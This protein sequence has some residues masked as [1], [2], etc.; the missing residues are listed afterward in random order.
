MEKPHTW[1]E[2]LALII[3]DTQQRQQIA[4]RLKINP[5]TLTRWAAGTS[6][7]RPENL[8]SLLNILPMREREQTRNAPVLNHAPHTIMNEIHPEFYRRVLS[9]YT[10]LPSTLREWSLNILIMQQILSHLDPQQQGM[11]VFLAYCSP[12]PD[13][14]SVRS[15]RKVLGRGNTPWNYTDEHSTQF[16]G[17]E[18]LVGQAILRGHPIIV[19]SHDDM[20]W[21]AL[22]HSFALAKSMCIFPLLRA[23]Q[24]AGSLCVMSAQT[25]FFSQVHLDL[26][27]Q[28]TNLLVITCEHKTF[29]EHE[30]ITLG[31]MPP[32]EQQ[33][34]LLHSFQQ[35]VMHYLHQ[36]T[37]QYRFL[38]KLE[39]ELLIW[40]EIEEE[41]L[42][43]VSTKD[44]YQ[45]RGKRS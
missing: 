40:Q 22:D 9:T 11:N 10:S 8:R 5:I 39:A 2:I 44:V 35:R 15:L 19:Q 29:V 12:T 16:F 36:A 6:N 27:Q 25:H 1:Q 33:L 23:N 7:P 30:A 37:R 41:L 13:G 3:R 45:E 4:D 34:P 28:Y 18:T 24:V 20:D 17:A 32:L 26:L 14:K 42:N 31:V 21:F 43:L 38:T